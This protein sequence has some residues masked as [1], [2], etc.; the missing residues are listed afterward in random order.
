MYIEFHLALF[1]GSAWSNMFALDGEKVTYLEK[2]IRPLIVYFTM[3][4]LLRIFGKRELAQL[5]PIDLVLLLLI[6]EDRAK[7]DYRRRHIAFRRNYRR[8]HLAYS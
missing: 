1:E 6:S 4:F 5:N 2:I 3:V 7:C 8:F